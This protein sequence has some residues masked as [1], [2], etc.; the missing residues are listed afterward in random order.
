HRSL[1]GDAFG[2][3]SPLIFGNG[4]R[5]FCDE[6]ILNIHTSILVFQHFRWEIFPLWQ[7]LYRYSGYRL[8]IILV[9]CLL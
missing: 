8:L 5:I 9:Q 1:R 2:W 3:Y 6:D 7:V 4:C